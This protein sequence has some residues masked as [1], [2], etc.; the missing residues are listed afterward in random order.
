MLDPTG[1]STKY[2][3]GSKHKSSIESI[4]EEKE[5]EQSVIVKRVKKVIKIN[6]LQLCAES[7]LILRYLND[8]DKTK[9]YFFNVLSSVINNIEKLKK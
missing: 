3:V 8:I 5:F 1:N 7:E 4:Y 2:L 6:S 9:I